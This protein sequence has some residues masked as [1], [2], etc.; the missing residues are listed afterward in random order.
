MSTLA[1]AR[2]ATFSSLTVPNYRLYFSGQAVSMIGTWMQTV[3]Q[4]W[5]VLQLTGSGTALGLVV[6]L[7]TLPVLLLGPYGGVVA[8]RVDKRRLMIALQSMMGVL[9][10]VLGLLTVTDTVALWQVY[11]LAFLLGLNNCFENPARQAF[12]LE[13]VGPEHLHNAVSLNSVLVNAARAIGPAVAGIVIATGGLG[14]CFLLNAVSFVAVVASLIK[15]DGSALQP[16]PPAVRSPGQLREGLRYVRRTPTLLVPLLMMALVGCLAYEFQVVLPVV[17]R[18][19]F[20]ADAQVY[21]FMTAA[22][23]A[24]AVVGGLYVAARGRTGVPALVVSSTIF[25]VVIAAAAL[26]PTLWLELVALVLVGAASVSFLSTGNSTLQLEAEPGMR[27]RVMALWSVAFLG[28]TPIG[29]PIAGAVSQQFGGRV[30][31][32]MGAAACLV[33][34]GLGAMVLRQARRPAPVDEPVQMA[35]DPVP[36]SVERP[37]TPDL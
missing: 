30:G 23:G 6:A 1:G 4:S 5:L 25:G 26:A 37:V 15:L 3:A 20:D 17:A 22:M 10:L 29:G 19:T 35:V 12:V 33:A 11:V 8:D 31:L 32:L 9:A 18:S 36:G 28:S 14:I 13:M 24:G 27:G 34:A 21:G 7:Q 16:S 2:R